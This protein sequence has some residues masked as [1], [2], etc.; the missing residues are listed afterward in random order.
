M[1]VLKNV[2]WVFYVGDDA[3]E[4][5][6]DKCGKWMYFFN[7]IDFAAEVCKKAV[8]QGVV[9]EAKHSNAESG[10]CCFY[11]NCDEVENHKKVISFFLENGLMKKTKTGKYYNI[12]FK[13]DEQ[14][15]SGEYG[16]NYVAELKLADFL[17]LNTGEWVEK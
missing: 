8:K 16:E 3:K 12:S 13:R 9:R 17:D 14:T 7:N 2:A 4:L 10:V 11:L 6:L 15:L 1:K 5:K